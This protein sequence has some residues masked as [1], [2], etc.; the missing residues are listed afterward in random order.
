LVHFYCERIYDMVVSEKLNKHQLF[1]LFNEMY[2]TS[3]RVEE[4]KVDYDY[5]VKDLRKN[6]F[7]ITEEVKTWPKKKTFNDKR[8]GDFVFVIRK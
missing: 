5:F 1:A 3:V 8:V 2:L 7:K 4:Y 6:G